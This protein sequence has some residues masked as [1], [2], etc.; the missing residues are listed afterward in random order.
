MFALFHFTCC[1]R[2]GQRGEGGCDL[3]SQENGWCCGAAKK[4]G[5]QDREL[6]AGGLRVSASKV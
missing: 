1:K 3:S 2:G 4:Q 6:Y 5:I